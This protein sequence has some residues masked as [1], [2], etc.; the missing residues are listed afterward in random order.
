MRKKTKVIYLGKVPIGGN[1][2]VTI[3]S[4]TKSDTGDLK[5]V[6]KE[7][8]GLE[9]IGCEIIRVSVPDIKSADNLSEI[10]KNIGIPLIADI[11]FNS[12]LA[13]QAIQNGVHGIRIN[14]GNIGGRK[15]IKEII[16]AAN[17]R[18][19]VIRVGVNSG[20]LDTKWINK[21]KG[22]TVKALVASAVEYTKII[23]DLGCTDLKISIKAPDI[24]RTI[25]SYR[26]LSKKLNYP[27]HIGV[28][29]AG[30]VIESAVRS[31][32]ALGTLLMEGIGDTLRVSVTGD[33]KK[34]VIIAKEILQSLGIRQ[35][36][37]Q[38]ISCP[39]CARCKVD[40]PKIVNELRRKLL[41][42][43][44]KK[45]CLPFKVAVMGCVVNGPGEAK[46]ADIGI[47][48]GTKYGVLFK[49]GK[50]TNHK[51]NQKNAVSVLLNE[52]V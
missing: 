39:T 50:P 36:G 9:K 4:M 15:K 19:T 22:I 38:I 32:I 31:S 42:V 28:T 37:P 51:I 35:L 49:K 1:N 24:K 44:C 23:E 46:E 25:E 29:E 14:P 47:A 3:Q 34:E 45:C 26:L 11:H 16:A 8:H 20:S 27:L 43:R 41:T 17:E 12:D 18:K 40:L 6:L 52:L 30:P 48:F 10:I 7:I 33:S 5:K 2:P 13:I 21:Y